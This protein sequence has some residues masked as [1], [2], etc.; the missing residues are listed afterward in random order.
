MI[1]KEKNMRNFKI[2]T[3][4]LASAIS[5]TLTSL[6]ANARTLKPYEA[7][8]INSLK[9]QITQLDRLSDV[10]FA[11][12]RSRLYILKLANTKVIS[13]IKNVGL[14]HQETTLAYQSYILRYRFSND[15]FKHIKLNQTEHY[16]KSIA[17]AIKNIL[18]IHSD[19][20]EARGLTGSNLYSHFTED[21][22]KQIKDL[23]QSAAKNQSINGE[24]KSIFKKMVAPTGQLLAKA[25]QG[26]RPS[27]FAAGKKLYQQYKQYYPQLF[28][29]NNAK[30]FDIIF[31]IQGLLELYYEFAEVEW[32][33]KNL[34]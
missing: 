16:Q 4:L 33:N 6:S 30:T 7:Q 26:D 3:V 5:L 31:Q 27:V 21:I 34:K 24:L 10:V 23:L 13:L 14:L 8:E 1:E 19:V 29:Y 11:T 20:E 2:I 25:K 9:S 17:H 18:Q 28:K 12:D 15:L 32:Q 22:F